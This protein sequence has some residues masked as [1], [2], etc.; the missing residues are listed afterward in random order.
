MSRL[1]SLPDPCA[2]MLALAASRLLLRRPDAALRDLAGELA[3][4]EALALAEERLLATLAVTDAPLA[5]LA[6]AARLSSFDLDLLGLAVLPALEDRAAEAVASLAGGARRLSAG[7]AARLLLPEAHDAAALRTA[8]RDSPLWR[9]GLMRAA[10]PALAPADRLLDPTPALLAALDGTWP[11]ATASGWVAQAILAE[12]SAP[13]SLAQALAVLEAWAG[14]QGAALLLLDAP[15][16]ERAEEALA[17]AA[18]AAGR[19][20]LLLHA[21]PVREGAH[22]AAPPPWAEAGV[23]AAATGA[24]VALVTEAEALPAPATPPIA[25]LAVIGPQALRGPRVAL[26][27][28]PVPRPRMAEQQAH[29]A[30]ALP[31]LPEAERV[32]L[33]AQTWAAEA[34][35][36]AMAAAAQGAAPADL[37]AARMATAPPRGARLAT[38]RIPAVPWP[39]LVLEAETEARLREVVRR[40][41]HRATV[42]EAW[43]LDHGGPALVALLSGEPGTGKSLAAEAVATELGLPLLAADLSRIVSKYIGETEKNLS[44]LFAAAEG[45]AAVLFFDEADALFGKRSA[46]QD[47]HDRYANIE[48]NYLLQR[49]ERFEGIALLATNLAQGMDEAFLRRFDL[50]VPIPRPGPA[51]RLA[52][53]RLHLPAALLAPGLDLPALA[54]GFD[55]TGGEIRNAA[56][57]AAYAAAEA[58]APIGAAALRAALMQ[59]FAKQ[60][61]PFPESSLGLAVA[62]EGGR[63]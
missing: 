8:L 14:G 30:R 31:G 17:R 56:L 57:T 24:L 5:R 7:R 28:L 19:V 9:A 10:D 45:F 58:A 44:E 32:A 25:P 20:A 6:R 22:D 4:P 37:L 26:T 2:L 13:A 42:R 23:M 12:G 61:R 27:R 51:Q 29:W 15:R 47:A 3:E 41:R 21:P 54:E 46:V 16:P 38:L 18:A 36:A 53:W 60:G 33:A 35:I 59:E 50:T 55:M 43:G 63:T 34:D 11:E 40:F 39:R 52:L 62:L 48:V 1:L 49:L